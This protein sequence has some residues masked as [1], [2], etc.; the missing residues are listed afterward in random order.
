MLLSPDAD[1]DIDSFESPMQSSLRSPMI[2]Q[3]SSQPELPSLSLSPSLVP[4]VSTSAHLLRRLTR[5]V[6]EPCGSDVHT[7]PRGRGAELK[8]LV[9]LL[10]GH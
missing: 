8:S 9:R 2:E 5:L 6:T 1:E 10:C 7:D 4:V 3:H